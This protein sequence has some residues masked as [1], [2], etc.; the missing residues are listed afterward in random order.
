MVRKELEPFL[1]KKSPSK[2]FVRSDS[3][4]IHSPTAILT[5]ATPASGKLPPRE[6]FDSRTEMLAAPVPL[7]PKRSFKAVG[8]AVAIGGLALAGVGAVV[9]RKWPGEPPP[10]PPPAAAVQP[11]AAVAPVPPKDEPPA[12][13]A[14]P[15]PQQHEEAPPSQELAKKEEAAP[16]APPAEPKAASQETLARVEPVVAPTADAK[17]ELQEKRKTKGPARIAH[18]PP[19]PVPVQPV[20]APPP[21][22]VQPVVQPAPAPPSRKVLLQACYSLKQLDRRTQQQE[23]LHARIACLLAR[24]KLDNG[25]QADTLLVRDL[26]RLSDASDEAKSAGDRMKVTLQLDEVQARYD[27]RHGRLVLE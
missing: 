17:P 18:K 3:G 8:A 10:S 22:P 21:P 13:E 2:E 11:V 23:L 26:A 24:S 27:S 1:P 20:P 25:G 12:A 9:L 7:K 15:A 19:E 14:S 5:P 6:S 4:R 16:P